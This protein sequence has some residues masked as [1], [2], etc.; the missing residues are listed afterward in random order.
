[1]AVAENLAPTQSWSRRVTLPQL[2]ALCWGTILTALTAAPL[3]VALVRGFDPYDLA[4]SPAPAYLAVGVLV[5]GVLC[6][7]AGVSGS[8]RWGW[9]LMAAAPLLL[10]LAGVV[11]VQLNGSALDSP[12]RLLGCAAVAL[13]PGLLILARRPLR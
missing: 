1:M 10:A 2:V 12:W 11:N 7:G 3:V 8:R 5:T 13:V 4:D 6:L 9:A